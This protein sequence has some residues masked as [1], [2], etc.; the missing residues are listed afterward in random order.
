MAAI[1]CATCGDEIRKDIETSDKDEGSDHGEFTKIVVGSIRA[2]G[3]RCNMCNR[4]IKAGEI[5]AY[6]AHHHRNNWPDDRGEWDYIDRK[7]VSAIVTF[8]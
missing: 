1:Y 2:D 7:N 5:A 6:V 4:P 8:K 3:C